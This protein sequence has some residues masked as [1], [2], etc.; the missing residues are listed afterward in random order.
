MMLLS[1]A[2]GALMLGG[3]LLLRRT[4]LAA[5]PLTPAAR[6]R[7]IRLIVLAGLLEASVSVLFYL[8]IV[9][10]G[11]VLTMLIMATTPVFS[12]VFGVVFLRERPGLRLTLAAVRHRRRRAHR[13]ARRPHLTHEGRAALPAARPS[14]HHRS[15]GPRVTS[16]C[17]TASGA[18]PPS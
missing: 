17:R 13:H 7:A 6:R 4:P 11:P 18:R 14:R 8:S 3:V 16:P 1:Q 9:A 10:L 12:I 2:L 15:V 5:R